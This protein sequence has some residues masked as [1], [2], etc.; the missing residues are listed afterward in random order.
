MNKKES[1]LGIGN[2]SA[3]PKCIKGSQSKQNQELTPLSLRD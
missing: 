3:Q 1:V 2:P